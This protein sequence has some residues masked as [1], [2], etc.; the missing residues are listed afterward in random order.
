M[1]LNN[2]KGNISTNLE[3]RYLV[4]VSVYYPVVLDIKAQGKVVSI[5]LKQEVGLLC[6]LPLRLFVQIV[7]FK[8]YKVVC[9]RTDD[10]V[11]VR[12]PLIQLGRTLELFF[13]DLLAGWID[14]F[15]HHGQ[16]PRIV[17][18]LFLSRSYLIK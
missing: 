1:Y 7:L 12:K 16:V 3:V 18:Q 9:C 11:I 4:V 15:K 5:A 17:S 13:L 6:L 10:K 14:A 8:M 2:S